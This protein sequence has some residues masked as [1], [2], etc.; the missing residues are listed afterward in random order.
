MQYL[1]PFPLAPDTPA[2]QSVWSNY[3]GA[4]R[5]SIFSLYPI[6]PS[7]LLTQASD[8]AVLETARRSVKRYT[9]PTTTKLGQ[10]RPVEAFPAAV[11]AGYNGVA[12][13]QPHEVLEGL[14]KMLVDLK[15]CDSQML[16][17]GDV[18]GGGGVENIGVTRAGRR[19]AVYRPIHTA[20]YPPSH[21]QFE[22]RA[23]VSQMYLRMY[24][25]D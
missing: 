18:T 3:D 14:E 11:R 19:F 17:T 8:E 22:Y 24:L 5:S 1:A 6:F 16:P 7:E 10:S 20:C 9:G 25:I 13:W 12:G 4:N 15:C 23:S 2:G 21:P